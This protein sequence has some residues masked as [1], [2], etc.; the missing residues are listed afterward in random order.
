MIR[1]T[2]DKKLPIH[3]GLVENIVRQCVANIRNEARF[4]AAEILRAGI[5]RIARKRLVEI[6]ILVEFV[7]KTHPDRD[8][9]PV[10]GGSLVAL[11][12]HWCHRI[13]NNFALNLIIAMVVHD[14]Q[15]GL[16]LDFIFQSRCKVLAQRR[17]HERGIVGKGGDGDGFR[18]RVNCAAGQRHRQ[19]AA[20]GQTG[21]HHT[22]QNPYPS[23]F[24]HNL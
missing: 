7:Y 24:H 17:V 20:D 10:H 11:N 9:E 15:R 8:G 2:I 13:V 21:G 4:H 19:A 1:N 16:A 6:Q 5:V 14:G 12:G 22:S 23:P 3:K 18:P